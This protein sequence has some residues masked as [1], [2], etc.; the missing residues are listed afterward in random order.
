MKDNND[1]RW[2]L[3]LSGTVRDDE[4]LVEERTE[5][6]KRETHRVPLET[7]ECLKPLGA[8]CEV[9]VERGGA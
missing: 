3:R 2:T 6:R 9:F 4:L 8:F 7:V 5:R 1:G